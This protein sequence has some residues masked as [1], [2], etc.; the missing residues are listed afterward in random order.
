[1]SGEKII[2]AI[3]SRVAELN[4]NCTSWHIGLTHEPN[5]CKTYWKKTENE[6]V[7]YWTQWQAV[8]FSDAQ[9]IERY[10]ISEKGME[11]GGTDE[12]L[13]PKKAVFVYIF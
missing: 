9:Y 2:A 3:L 5:K 11:A 7:S 1:M 13:S 12:E 8:S 10:F 4:T 6:N